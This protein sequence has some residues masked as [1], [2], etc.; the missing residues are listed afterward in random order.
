MKFL[1]ILTLFISFYSQALLA[2]DWIQFCQNSKDEMNHP[3]LTC[4]KS[5]IFDDAFLQRSQVLKELGSKF[6][7]WL[8]IK[9]SMENLKKRYQTEIDQEKNFLRWLR[10]D[11]DIESHQS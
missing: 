7:D 9:T 11:S 10:G 8:L 2:R 5:N 6:D 4:N 3:I 1:S